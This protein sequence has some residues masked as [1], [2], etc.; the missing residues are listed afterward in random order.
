MPYFN[1]QLVTAVSPWQRRE[2]LHHWWRI[3]QSDHRWTPPVYAH[4]RWATNPLLNPHLARLQPQFLHVEALHRQQQGMPHT[5]RIPLNASLTETPL[6]AGILLHDPRRADRAAHLALVHCANEAEAFETLLYASAERLTAAGIRR[7][8]AFTGLSPHLGSG[9]LT[10]EW[11]HDPPW[12]TP[13]NP[14]YLPELVEKWLHPLTTGSLYHLP[15]PAELSPVSQ[16][17]T[18]R[19]LDANR[20]AQ[21]LLP[22]LETAVS[23]P[24]FPPPD[25]AEAAFLLRWLD[26]RTLRG[27]LAEIQGRPVGFLLLQPDLG[28][29]LRQT[30]GKPK[31]LQQIW[32][33]SPL[34]PVR[35]GRL[36]LG[37]VLPAYRRQ[38]IGRQLLSKAMV[39]AQEQGWQKL[40]IGPVWQG[41]TAV[42]F[43]LNLQAKPSQTFRLYDWNF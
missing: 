33:K 21:D 8:V 42:K 19:P 17:A 18:L 26:P 9:L 34:R 39:A 37:G 7:L 13:Y 6:A 41:E 28:P 36:L 27:W 29:R 14:P 11:H 12:H 10:N 3:Y 15:V 2:F 5:G 4:L 32:L 30:R 24:H 25:Q 43:L 38:G 23:T 40:V 16:P 22:L 31:W 35:Q 1:Y 20:L